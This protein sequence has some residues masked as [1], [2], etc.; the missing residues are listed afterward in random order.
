MRQPVVHRGARRLWTTQFH[1]STFA[2]M[3]GVDRQPLRRLAAAHLGLS[4]RRQAAACGYSAYQIR[5][6]LNDGEW[7]RVLGSTYAAAGLRVTTAILD[8]AAQLAVPGSTLA[9]PSAARTY[10][11]P[12]P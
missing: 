3:P 7:Q 5:R 10:G 4:S 6:R 8:R 1:A 9:G 2:M 11:I 12:V